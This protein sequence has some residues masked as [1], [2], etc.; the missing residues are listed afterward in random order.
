[1]PIVSGI[2]T[3]IV[4]GGLI[5]KG[6]TTV[7]GIDTTLQIWGLFHLTGKLVSVFLGGLD[8][9]DFTVAADGSV[10]VSLLATAGQP[11]A[12]SAAQLVAMDAGDGGYG[13]ST[14]LVQLQAGA[15]AVFINIPCV[16]GLPYITQGQR[17]RLS[18]FQDA[19]T[20][21]GPVLGESRRTHMWSALLQNTV[22]I[23]FGT[24]LTPAPTGNMNE[25]DQLNPDTGVA[26][27]AGEQF[28][29]V[30]WG[31]LDDGYSF[32]S[33]LCWQVLRPYPATVCSVN[34]FVQVQ[35]RNKK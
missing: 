15:G 34:Q 23:S 14:T 6:G 13:E 18:T 35:E 25:W 29:G 5:G 2:S 30:A 17:L 9:G 1:M 12:W 10:T 24:S 3:N 32:D 21:T 28:S 31:T 33:E 8:L 22:Q 19:K 7:S 11:N 27:A 16:I 4:V 26:L 20:Q